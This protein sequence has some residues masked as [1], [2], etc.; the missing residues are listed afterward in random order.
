MKAEPGAWSGWHH[1][2]EH[3]TSQH[4]LNGSIDFENG[5]E[6][7]RVALGPGQFGHMPHHVIHRERT[8]PGQAEVVLVRIG[9]G[10]TMLNFEG[11]G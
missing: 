11:S 4:V 9:H 2:G 5:P 6:R 3:D 1:Y 10:P 8:R 7:A